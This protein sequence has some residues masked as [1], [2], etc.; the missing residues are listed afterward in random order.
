MDPSEFEGLSD[1]IIEVDLS[2][3]D[4]LEESVKELEDY[5]VRLD[6]ISIK[7]LALVMDDQAVEIAAAKEEYQSRRKELAK[8]IR[9]F[10]GTHLAPT[11]TPTPTPGSEQEQEHNPMIKDCTELISVF[12]TEFDR[13]TNLFRV[14]EVHL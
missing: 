1:K 13:L 8:S 5:I 9:E 6:E 4:E 14:T 11:P 7:S 12:K 3:V 10:V 2:I